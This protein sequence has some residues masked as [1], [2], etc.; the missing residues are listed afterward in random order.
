MFSRANHYRRFSLS[1]P[2]RGHALFTMFIFLLLLISCSLM[3]YYFQRSQRQQRE[4]DIWRAG[5]TPTQS[6]LASTIST[7]GDFTTAFR[8]SVTSLP[9][10]GMFQSLSGATEAAKLDGAPAT[11][12]FEPPIKE[13]DPSLARVPDPDQTPVPTATPSAPV[14]TE[15]TAVSASDPP[16]ASRPLAVEVPKSAYAPEVERRRTEEIKSRRE[17]PQAAIPPRATPVLRLRS[18]ARA[19]QPTPAA[20][21]AASPITDE[22]GSMLRSNS[23]R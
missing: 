13:P 9:A 5:R 18:P 3:Y 20:G 8:D 10:A 1:T 7:V 12:N 11:D 6:E 15:P 21:T 23:R 2:R 4:L 22:I 19:T 14:K 17:I 16:R